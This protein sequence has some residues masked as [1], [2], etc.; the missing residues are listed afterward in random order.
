MT[1]FLRPFGMKDVFEPNCKVTVSGEHFFSDKKLYTNFY[2]IA[3]FSPTDEYTS[4]PHISPVLSGFPSILDDFLSEGPYS[5]SSVKQDYNIR[6]NI[7]R[8]IDRKFISPKSVKTD[9]PGGGKKLSCSYLGNVSFHGDDTLVLMYGSIL[10]ST[11]CI[12][13]NAVSMML[14]FSPF[15][16]ISFV[17]GKRTLQ[18]IDY[19]VQFSPFL[20]PE[21][22]AVDFATYTKNL[23]LMLREDL[24]GT[25]NIEY[26]LEVGASKCESGKL[27]ID[28]APLPKEDTQFLSDENERN[29]I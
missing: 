29:G 21:N 26:Y 24:T 16:S 8:N 17:K 23:S 13:D 25:L 12:T 11:V 4:N 22:I 10:P 27:S 2:G 7:M 6:Q 20:P 18:T 28:F 3:F 14:P 19:P 1:D 15:S 9:I 5:Q